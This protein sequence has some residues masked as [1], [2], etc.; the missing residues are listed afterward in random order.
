MEFSVFSKSP[1]PF[2]VVPDSK[3]NAKSTIIVGGGGC[4]GAIIAGKVK[5]R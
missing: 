3:F 5:E 1:L 4:C 2:E